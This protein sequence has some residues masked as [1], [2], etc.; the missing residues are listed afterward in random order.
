MTFNSF[1]KSN[2]TGVQSTSFTDSEALKLINEI[3]VNYVDYEKNFD[4]LKQYNKTISSLSDKEYLKVASEN[5]LVVEK[6]KKEIA[7]M[8]RCTERLGELDIV[9]SN[10]K[11]RA[12]ECLKTVTNKVRPRQSDL[13]QIVGEINKKEKIKNESISIALENNTGLPNYDKRGSAMSTGS[14]QNQVNLRE[15]LIE[16]KDIEFNQQLMNHREKELIEI[17]KASAQVKDL[18]KL[19]GVQVEEQGQLINN[20]ESNVIESKENVI[21]ADEQITEADKDVKSTGK[22]LCIIALLVVVVV[23]IVVV[24][25]VLSTLK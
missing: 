1:A 20:L 4:T 7:S 9:D 21:K 10:L 6:I 13:E 11:G 5:R 17:Q 22:K 12:L 19:M 23:A 18:T 2:R 8:I 3:E 25:V 14:Y 24:V 15:S 16:V